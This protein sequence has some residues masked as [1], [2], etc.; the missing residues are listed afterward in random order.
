MATQTLTKKAVSSATRSAAA[1]EPKA[2]GKKAPSK[3]AAAPAATP[4]GREALLDA[5]VRQ[6]AQQGYDKTSMRDI[7]A[8]AGMLAGSIYYYFPTK[9]HLFLAVHEHA[10]AHICDRVRRAMRPEADPW[11]RLT[12][13]AQ[14]YL[15]SMLSEFEYAGVIITEFPR[16]RSPELRAPLLAHRRQFEDIFTELIK[17]L[18]LRRGVDRTY[19]R[20]AFLGMLAWSYTWYNPSGPDSPKVVAQKMVNLLRD[21]TQ[22]A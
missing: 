16:R 21:S 2:G 14:G 8:L 1:R 3:V 5:A 15:E 12:Q 13:A 10:I 22:P 17:D 6:F 4:I 18:P 19:F 9:E 20:L 11:T 7:A